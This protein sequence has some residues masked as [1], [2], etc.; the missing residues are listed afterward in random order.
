MVGGFTDARRVIQP[1]Q[2]DLPRRELELRVLQ[3]GAHPVARLLDLGV[4]QPDEIERREA[5]VEVPLDGDER[6]SEA[7][8]TRERERPRATSPVSFGS[9]TVH[10]PVRGVTHTAL[11]R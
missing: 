10:A 11:A 5:T 9:A 3:R 7:R 6:R 2:Y 8:A 4:R 1:L